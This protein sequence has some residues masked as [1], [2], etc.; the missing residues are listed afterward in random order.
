MMD[1]GISESYS[2]L[3]V[4]FVGRRKERQIFRQKYFIAAFWIW[5]FKR[6]YSDWPKRHKRFRLILNSHEIQL[7]NSDDLLVTGPDDQFIALERL[8][9]DPLGAKALE[10]FSLPSWEHFL[11]LLKRKTE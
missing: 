9:Q 5:I 1:L 11:N 6:F 2:F 7:S 4:K 3:I 8:V 10:H